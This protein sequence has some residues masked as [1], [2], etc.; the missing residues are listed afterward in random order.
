[1]ASPIDL[2]IGYT[3]QRLSA[4]AIDLL[5]IE[6]ARNPDDAHL[7]VLLALN[8]LHEGRMTAAEHEA[9]LGVAGAA[10]H[11]GAHIAMGAVHLARGHVA[12]AQD[13]CSQAVRLA[14]D[15]P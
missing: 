11:A 12:E 1:M 2:I 3:R 15:D 5:R 10:A 7:H 4:K 14:P 6:L 13:S 8:L 9:R